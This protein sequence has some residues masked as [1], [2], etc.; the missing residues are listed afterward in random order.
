MRFGAF[1]RVAAW[2]C[3]VDMNWFG[4]KPQSPASEETLSWGALWLWLG[5]PSH[6]ME[7]GAQ[8]PE[9]TCIFLSSPNQLCETDS[10]SQTPQALLL[11]EAG[12]PRAWLGLG[13]Q[14][15]Q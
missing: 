10:E 6:R 3:E 5:I 15:L 11:E 7:L 1:R 4:R 9:F 12:P 14:L 8:T 2:E 13:A